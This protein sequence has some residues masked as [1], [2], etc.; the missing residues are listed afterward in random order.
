MSEGTL[1]IESY[2]VGTTAESTATII[3]KW[4]PTMKCYV[5]PESCRYC[6]HAEI[7]CSLEKEKEVSEG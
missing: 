2:V 6:P 5:H 3:L 7:T 1:Q 4:C